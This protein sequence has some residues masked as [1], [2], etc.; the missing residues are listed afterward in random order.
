MQEVLRVQGVEDAGRG[1]E[2]KA[3]RISFARG[4]FRQMFMKWNQEGK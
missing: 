1:G 3:G 4:E 2:G